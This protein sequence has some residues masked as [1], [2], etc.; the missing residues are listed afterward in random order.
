MQQDFSGSGNLE[1]LFE[2]AEGKLLLSVMPIKGSAAQPPAQDVIYLPLE[3][4]TV[5]IG[6]S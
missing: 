3:L 5:E 1:L 2:T 6:T 4:S